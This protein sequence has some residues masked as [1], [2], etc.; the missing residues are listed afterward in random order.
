MAHLLTR[1]LRTSRY[2]PVTS[3]DNVI[4]QKVQSGL[5]VEE[6]YFHSLLSRLSS[7]MRQSVGQGGQTTSRLC[8][9]LNHLLQALRHW[10]GTLTIEQKKRKLST[11]SWSTLIFTTLILCLNSS[12]V[13][14]AFRQFGC[15]PVRHQMSLSLGNAYAVCAKEAL[16]CICTMQIYA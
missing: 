1:H 4:Y 5:R 6:S 11:A 13:L 14:N 10:I 8:P 15:S 9:A 16:R 3:M 7:I 12:A 2:C